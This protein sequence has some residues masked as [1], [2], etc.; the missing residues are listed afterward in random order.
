[1]AMHGWM[2]SWMLVGLLVAIAV[3]GLVIAVW[4]IRHMKDS[5]SSSSPAR[6]ELDM[7]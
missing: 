3:L 6:N 5:P 1:M 7:R 4:L 2:W